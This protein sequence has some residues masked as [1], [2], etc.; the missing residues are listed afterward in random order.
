MNEKLEKLKNDYLKFEFYAME[1][2][3]QEEFEG[4]L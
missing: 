2:V 1:R 4:L 3:S